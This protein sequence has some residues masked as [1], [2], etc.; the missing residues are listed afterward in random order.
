MRVATGL[1][2][3]ALVCVAVRDARATGVQWHEG[4]LA[5][6][7]TRAQA[8][9]KLVFIDVYASWCTPCHQM[10]ADIFPRDEVAR[11]M[12]AGYVALRVDG[13]LG[14]GLELVN[15]YHVAGFP[16]L[17]VLDARGA[18]I[19]RLMG[20]SSP[21]ELVRALG[22]FRE[23]KGGLAELERE[24]ARA[25]TD[26]LRFEVAMRH[27]MRAD[28][29]A[30]AEIAEVVKADPHNHERRAA[31]AL[32]TLSVNYYA[33]GVK[34]YAHADSTLA[35]LERRFPTSAEAERAP[36][37][38]AVALQKAGRGAAARALLDAWIE[39]VP[40]DVQR[41]ASYAWFCFK[42]GGDRARG[43]VIARR[44]LELEPKNDA[45]WDTLGEL[46]LASGDAVEARKAFS[47]AAELAPKKDY[48][49]RQLRKLGGS[50]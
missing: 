42:D 43:L 31:T 28:A 49:Q 45:L 35:E 18:E 15:R 12:S 20:A 9:K 6:A 40:N 14:E 10:D 2:V 7:L 3:S 33:R 26:A 11:T 46:Y 44:G 23:G 38:R 36:Y 32:M 37:Y 41:L 30:V 5:S 50:P 19:E 4:T 8:E 34:D 48:Y 16:T 21:S 22:H 39:R 24:L 13:E 47:R 17:L 29:R 1:L 27:A 25:P